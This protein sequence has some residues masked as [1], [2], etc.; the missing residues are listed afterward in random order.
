MWAFGAT[1][2]EISSL[3]PLFPGTNETDQLVKQ[4]NLLGYPSDFSNIGMWRNTSILAHNVRTL[5]PKVE[6]FPKRLTQFW[7]IQ[8]P[9]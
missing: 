9:D 7:V 8:K 1:A 4:I 5:V 6:Q 3:K 2:T